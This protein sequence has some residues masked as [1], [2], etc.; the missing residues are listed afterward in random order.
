MAAQVKISIWAT[1]AALV[2]FTMSSRDV[3]GR[4]AP[5][6]GDADAN[7]GVYVMDVELFKGMTGEQRG[8][9]FL[10]QMI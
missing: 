2:P 4:T 3:Y 1:Y 8:R 6:T 5:A 10:P 7:G 9:V